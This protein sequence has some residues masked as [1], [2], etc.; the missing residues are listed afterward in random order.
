M[1]QVKTLFAI[2]LVI[3][4]MS[5]CGNNVKPNFEGVLMQNYGRGGVSD[6]KVQTGKAGWLWWGETLY[7]VPMWEQKAD[8]SPIEIGTKD[9]GTFVVDPTFTYQAIRGKG[10]NI[11]FNY[12]HVGVDD[13]Q[14]IMDNI[15]I[16]VLNSLVTDAYRETSRKFTT[17]S[18]MNNMNTFERAVEE[19]L[20][21]KFITKFFEL[22]NLTSGLKPPKSMIDAIERTN[23]AKQKT[24]QLKKELEGS[25]IRQ[26]KERIDAE[27]NRIRNAGLTKELLTEQWIEAIRNT[28]NKVIITDG[29]VPLMINN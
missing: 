18:L 23:T 4:T 2:L 20:E 8:P 13:E 29:K 9:A 19:R 21:K 26:E 22:K 10:V 28:Q 17:D 6:F 25:K 16:N 11:I 24:E 5:S 7:Q 27:T 12:R 14:T 3:A 1:K 15:E